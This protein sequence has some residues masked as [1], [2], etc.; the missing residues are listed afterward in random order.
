MKLFLTSD[1]KNDNTHRGIVSL[2]LS[3]L[4]VLSLLSGCAQSPVDVTPDADDTSVTDI[5]EATDVEDVEDDMPLGVPLMWRVTSP[6]GQTMYLFGS[7]HVADDEIYP[8]PDFI[9]NAFNAS[10]YLAVE[11]DLLAFENDELAQQALALSLMY[12]DG[13]TIVDEIGEELHERAKAVMAELDLDLE[14]MPLEILDL[15]K[16]S[17]WVTMLTAEA[18][19][20]AGMSEE[21]GLDKFFLIEA[22]ERGMEI[23]EIES[24]EAQIE[25]F[26]GFSAPLQIFLLEGALNVDEVAAYLRELYSMWKQGDRQGIE[27]LANSESEEMDELAE[28]YW[29]ALLTQR[30]LIMVEV[31]RRY[32]AE[33]KNVF[34]VVGLLHMIGENGIVEQLIQHGYIVEL[35]RPN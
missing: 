13:R 12:S 16:P 19:E 20:R 26:V 9:M 2:I 31:A 21:F 3:V 5:T 22:A 10:D 30:D 27:A 15:F 35:V 29:D 18:V 28:E 7:I 32:M 25:M 17:F 6:D 4:L 34:Y 8:L 11:V 23:L 14:G 33:G 24:V 1:Q